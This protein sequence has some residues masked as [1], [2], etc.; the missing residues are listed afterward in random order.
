[1]N[2]DDSD[3]LSLNAF[4]CPAC[5]LRRTFH[6]KAATGAHVP[7]SLLRDGFCSRCLDW[8]TEQTGTLDAGA[9]EFEKQDEAMN[10]R[11]DGALI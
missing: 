7:L 4:G 2:D 3:D 6:W 1:M 8:L 9:L 11:L 10:R 5:P